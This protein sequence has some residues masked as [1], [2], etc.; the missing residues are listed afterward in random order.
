MMMMKKYDSSDSGSATASPKRLPPPLQQ[1]YVQSPSSRHDSAQVT[2]ACPSPLQSPSYSSSCVDSSAASTRA[3]GNWRRRSGKWWRECKVIEE[4]VDEEEE[5]VRGFC[6]KGLI[7]VMVLGLVFALSCL[8]IWSASQPYKPS[9][10]VKGL[11][12]HNLYKGEGS[13][14]TGVPTRLLTINGSVSMATYNPSPFFGIHLAATPIN[15]IYS[16]IIVAA[17]EMKEYYQARKSYREWALVL[18]G[19]NVP[20]YGTG[21]SLAGLDNNGGIPLELDLVMR[22]KGYLV[23]KLVKTKQ[24]RHVSCSLTIKLS[25]GRST[26]SKYVN[27]NDSCT[28]T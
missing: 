24:Q 28:Y 2:P 3:S 18:E 26:T 1:Y 23:G 10:I 11:R 13:D 25:S 15:L 14:H 17:G 16:Q 21:D 6:S 9:I 5:G 19:E 12:V 4:E 7:V 27:L 22:S 8:L 20:L